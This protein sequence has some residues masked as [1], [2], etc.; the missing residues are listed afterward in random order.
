MD[1]VLRGATMYLFL[2]VVFRLAGRRTLAQT[3]VFDLALL[4]IISEATQNAMLGQDYS[5]THGI[6]VILTLVGLDI[7][8]SLL[9]QRAPF[10]ARWIDG[11]PLVL[12]DEG[13]PLGD[14]MRRA[15]VDLE[16]I[17]RAGREQGV[18]GLHRIRYAVL[19]T[20]GT[21]SIIPRNADE[22]LEG[23]PIPPSRD[24]S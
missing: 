8:L 12:I 3:T 2:L 23:R 19:E 10:L 22:E 11:K 6:L 18:E 15:R 17:L 13:R 24:W 20:S 14:L 1:A 5:V 16:D 9:K 21:I 7:L 4:L